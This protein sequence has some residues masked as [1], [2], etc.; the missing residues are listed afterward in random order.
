MV[1]GKKVFP[2]ASIST[3]STISQDHHNISKQPP[4]SSTL[5][6]IIAQKQVALTV[7]T[8][9]TVLNCLIHPINVCYKRDYFNIIK[10]NIKEK[11]QNLRNGYFAKMLFQ[12]VKKAIIQIWQSVYDKVC[13]YNNKWP[14]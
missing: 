9:I 7:Q 2:D 14:S 8:F 12:R 3:K 11:I 6:I 10:W 13:D 5:P 1:M 4:L